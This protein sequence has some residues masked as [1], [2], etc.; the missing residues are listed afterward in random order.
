[1]SAATASTTT[2]CT[3]RYFANDNSPITQ[4]QV[5]ISLQPDPA[6]A[7]ELCALGQLGAG[8]L[9]GTHCGPL[10]VNPNQRFS[11]ETQ[12]DWSSHEITFSSTLE[13]ARCSGSPALYY[14]WETDNNPVTDQRAA[15]AA[16][17]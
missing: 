15:A 16:A 10:T 8:P 5:P 3:I 14:Y 4:Y 2:N 11:Y 17:G 6:P 13:Q 12:T 1:M 9:A 7:N